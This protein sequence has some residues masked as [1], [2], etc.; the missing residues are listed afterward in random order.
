M[1]FTTPSGRKKLRVK[2]TVADSGAQIT[3]FPAS[4]IKA[5]GVQLTGMRN[6]KVDL[7][8]ANNARIE[9]Q[10]VV[11][12]EITALSPSGERF[13]TTSK[14]YIV[15]NVDKVYLSFDVLVGLRFF[16]WPARA[17][18]TEQSLVRGTAQARSWSNFH[19]SRTA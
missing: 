16:R 4:L 7:R 17:I 15:Q 10:G 11:V 19:T 9:V 5:S 8:V 1:T 18:N 14:V 12:A 3:I 2:D 13:K 6:S